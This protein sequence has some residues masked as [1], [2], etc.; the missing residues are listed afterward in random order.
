MRYILD[1]ILVF[2]EFIEKDK[3]SYKL[4]EHFLEFVLFI[5]LFLPDG[6]V[7]EQLSHVSRQA[8]ATPS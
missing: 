8:S 6:D 4:I 7:L 2:K 1:N 5:E 3:E